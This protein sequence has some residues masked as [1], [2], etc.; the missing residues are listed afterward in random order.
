MA[1]GAV[2]AVTSGMVQRPQAAASAGQQGQ[3]PQQLGTPSQGQPE[4]CTGRHPP[5]AQGM[6]TETFKEPA[7]RPRVYDGRYQESTR[8][9]CA[10]KDT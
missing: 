7:N 10:L 2:G 5:Y 8:D 9:G 4:S 6:S 1:I 3:T